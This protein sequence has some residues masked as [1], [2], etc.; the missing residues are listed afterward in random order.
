MVMTDYREEKRKVILH[1]FLET[2]DISY[3]MIDMTMS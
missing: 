3:M 1:L 2:L